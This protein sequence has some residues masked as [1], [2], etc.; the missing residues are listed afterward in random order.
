MFCQDIEVTPERKVIKVPLGSLDGL[1]SQVI[2]VTIDNAWVT[3]NTPLKKLVVSD[4]VCLCQM[5]I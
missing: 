5:V 1:E 3:G 2:K 4:Q